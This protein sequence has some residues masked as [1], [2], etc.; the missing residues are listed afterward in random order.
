MSAKTS[1]GFE[2]INKVY[3]HANGDFALFTEI[4]SMFIYFFYFIFR[5]CF[6]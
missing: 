6:R 1:N 3:A 4:F 2:W 5:Y